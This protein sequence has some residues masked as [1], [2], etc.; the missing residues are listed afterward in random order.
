MSLS[1]TFHQTKRFLH[2]TDIFGGL[3]EQKIAMT[4]Q[5]FGFQIGQKTARKKPN[6]VQKLYPTTVFNI[7]LTTYVF[8]LTAINQIILCGMYKL[9]NVIIKH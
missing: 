2:F 6:T 4:V 3:F 5:F 9:T 1:T 7:G 8:S